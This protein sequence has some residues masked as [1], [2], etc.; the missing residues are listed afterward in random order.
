MAHFTDWFTTLL[1]VADMQPPADRTI[2]GINLLPVL[3]GETGDICER[4]FWQWNRYTPVKEC[5]AA[6]RDG[7]WKLV[8]PAIPEAME[9]IDGEAE[10][11]HRSMYTP[12]YFADHS[13]LDP[14]PDRDLPEP[15]PP[16][17]YNIVADPEE[18]F[19]LAARNPDR[20][21]TL[22]LALENWFDE[23]EAERRSHTS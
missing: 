15:S 5:N 21:R 1:A 6:I 7:D 14:D 3:R 10:W 4:R 2:D 13:L 18:R 20:V 11:L 9:V 12:E 23:V 19:N 16:E 22:R 8:F 17:L